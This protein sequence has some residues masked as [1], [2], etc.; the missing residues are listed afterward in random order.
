MAS[1]VLGF[2][3]VVAALRLTEKVP[4]PVI[5]TLPPPAN[6]E[7]TD[8]RKASKAL[9]ASALLKPDPEAIASISS[10]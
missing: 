10:F 8:P 3:P 9:P 4:K 1:P 2:L 6:A 5:F 7:V